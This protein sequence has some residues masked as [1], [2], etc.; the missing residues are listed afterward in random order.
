M[1]GR[2]QSVPR[3][4][5]VSGAAWLG[6][7]LWGSLGSCAPSSITSSGR[8]PR[9]SPRTRPCATRASGALRGHGGRGGP[10]ANRQLTVCC[11]GAER[12]TGAE[13]G[14]GAA[15]SC[16]CGSSARLCSRPS[17]LKSCS[18][19]ALRPCRSPHAPFRVL[20]RHVCACPSTSRPPGRAHAPHAHAHHQ[21]PAVPGQHELVRDQGAVYE[22]DERVSHGRPRGPQRPASHLRARAHCVRVRDGAAHRNTRFG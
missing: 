19:R 7:V 10:G 21:D 4:L 18:V 16:S 17:S 15:G 2:R 5:T 22:P 11:A 8:Q 13:R 9:R 1:R 20:I 6:V 12:G 14:M 3:S